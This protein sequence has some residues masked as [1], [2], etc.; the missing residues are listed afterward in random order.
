MDLRTAVTHEVGH[1][2]GLQHSDS[3]TM[4]ATMHANANIQAT[5]AVRPRDDSMNSID[6]ARSRIPSSERSEFVAG[7]AT[8]RLDTASYPIAI[9]TS[10][11]TN[12]AVLQQYVGLHQVARQDAVQPATPPSIFRPKSNRAVDALTLDRVLA[13]DDAMSLPLRSNA[14]SR[15]ASDAGA[16][17]SLQT[18]QR[19]LDRT[20]VL[21]PDDEVVDHVFSC[22][23]AW[24]DEA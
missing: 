2:L 4:A 23:N 8:G 13:S 15:G 16:T 5:A 18:M 1:V 10:D 11:G 21:L 22:F 24:I 6:A 7:L 20:E 14:W 17:R 12:P 9:V 3:G 19:I